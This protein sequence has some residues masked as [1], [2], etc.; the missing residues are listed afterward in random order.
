VAPGGVVE[1]VGVGVGV[2]Q[3]KEITTQLNMSVL[4]YP[5]PNNELST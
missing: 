4:V 2:A 1:G 5:E 3:P